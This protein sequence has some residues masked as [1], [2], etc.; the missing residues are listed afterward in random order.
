[1]APPRRIDDK[2]FVKTVIDAIEKG[3][4]PEI[5]L[6]A[7]GVSVSSWYEWKDKAKAGVD[8]F[9][10]FLGLIDMAEAQSE[11]N[12][13]FSTQAAAQN[14]KDAEFE[15][16]KCGHEMRWQMFKGFESVQKAFSEAAKISIERL[17]RRFPRR[18]AAVSRIQVEDEQRDFLDRLEGILAP[19]VYRLVLKAY[20]AAS[21][22]EEASQSPTR[23]ELHH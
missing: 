14:A 21:G 18:W 17:S 10:E 6:R 7:E 3:A 2:H 22:G 5:A 13:I 23:S 9:G 4:T 1:M 15:C 8:G 12:D 19:E 20:V 16:P 11:L